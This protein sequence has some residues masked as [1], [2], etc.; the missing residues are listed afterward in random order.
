MKAFSHVQPSTKEMTKMMGQ[1]N[2]TTD[3]DYIDEATEG[4]SQGLSDDEEAHWRGKFKD[5]GVPMEL[6]DSYNKAGRHPQ[7]FFGYDVPYPDQG[8]EEEIEREAH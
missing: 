4:G 2:V 5:A 6:F 7:E 8:V 3:P 1:G